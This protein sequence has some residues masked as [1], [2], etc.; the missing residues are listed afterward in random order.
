MTVAPLCL[1]TV[2]LRLTVA[3]FC[4]TVAPLCL[5]DCSPTLSD[6]SSTLTDCSPTLTDYSSTL[7]DYSPT[8]S[9]CSLTLTAASSL[10]C[11][12]ILELLGNKTPFLHRP[13]HLIRETRG[14]CP[15]VDCLLPSQAQRNLLSFLHA[16]PSLC[17]SGQRPTCSF[18]LQLLHSVGPHLG[19]LFTLSWIFTE[20]GGMCEVIPQL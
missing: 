17:P 14:P 16:S 3:P 8:L 20:V 2:P 9:G 1:T 19:P 11:V 10:L 7:T 15:A 12:C 5:T 13:Y 18:V 4:L 6:C